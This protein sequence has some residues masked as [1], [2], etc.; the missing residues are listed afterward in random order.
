MALGKIGPKDDRVILA[1]IATMRDRDRDVRYAAVEALA[2][3]G[4]PAFP[5]LRALL[6]DDNREVRDHAALTLSRIADPIYNRAE[7]ETDE[8]A[9]VRVKAPR[10]ALFAALKDPDERVRAGASRALG[11]LGKEIVS[12]LA[13]ALSDPSPFFRVQASRALEFIGGEARSSLDALRER[14]GDPDP[15]VRR[16][17]E[18]AINAIRKSDP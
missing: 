7:D 12:G 5:G 3:I 10:E 4:M 8:Q 14:L 15:E 2:A 18:A 6:R 17:A 9:S 16:A 1:L 13:M 11:Y